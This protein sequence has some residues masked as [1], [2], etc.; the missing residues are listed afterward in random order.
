MST[1]VIGVDIHARPG[2]PLPDE[3]KE[4]MRA[5]VRARFGDDPDKLEDVLGKLEHFFE[6]F[7]KD[8][9]DAL[10]AKSIIDGVRKIDDDLGQFP[11]ALVSLGKSYSYR[12]DGE[13]CFSVGQ[14]QGALVTAR[15]CLTALVITLENVLA[16]DIERARQPPAQAEVTPEDG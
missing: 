5:H 3:A 9:V 15:A 12:G 6:R 11:P 8:S 2:E 4:A 1:E 7:A 13:Q 10:S 16:R 14:A